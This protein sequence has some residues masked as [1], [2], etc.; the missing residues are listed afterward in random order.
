MTAAAPLFPVLHGLAKFWTAPGTVDQ[1]LFRAFSAHLRRES[2]INGSYYRRRHWA[3]MV[4]QIM[5]RLAADRIAAPA[6][7]TEAE[8]IARR[9]ALTTMFDLHEAPQIK[10]G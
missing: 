6:Q 4:D 1:T 7:A 3:G 2:L 10:A 8:C 5:R 9:A